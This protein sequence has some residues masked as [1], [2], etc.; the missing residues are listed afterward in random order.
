M[1]WPYE[2]QHG[3]WMRLSSTSVFG[4]I[5]SECQPKKKKPKRT[6]KIKFKF[7]KNEKFSRNRPRNTNLFLFHCYFKFKS[8]NHLDYKPFDWSN[9][10]KFSSP[11]KNKQNFHL[12]LFYCEFHCKNAR[13]GNET[14]KAKERKTM[15]KKVWNSYMN[16]MNTY[17][18][19]WIWQCD[20]RNLKLIFIL[21]AKC[22]CMCYKRSWR[23]VRH[24]PNQ[25]YSQNEKKETK[26]A[27]WFFFSLKYTNI[28][29][30]ISPK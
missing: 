19:W 3:H 20:S 23:S 24:Q 25:M 30:I 18:E 4:L 21:V 17:Y 2:V 15:V 27:E 28:F 6:Q 8:F 11:K 9:N 5:V 29:M 12:K 22:S 16:E 13:R 1:L 7:E 10:P 26:N 14:E